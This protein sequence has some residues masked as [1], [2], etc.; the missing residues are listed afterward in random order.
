MAGAM[1]FEVRPDALA[2]SEVMQGAKPCVLDWH[3]ATTWPAWL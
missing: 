2:E 1:S 3:A